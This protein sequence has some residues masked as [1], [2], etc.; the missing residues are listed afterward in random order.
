MTYTDPEVAQVGH[1]ELSA[2]DAGIPFEVTTYGIDDLDRAIAESEDHGQVKVLTVPGKDT[3]IGAN[4]VSH[5][6]GEM[7]AEF[8]TAM[9]YGIGMNKILGTIHSYPSFVEAN[10][11]A[12][13]NWK[14]AHAPAG[15]LEFVKKFHRWRR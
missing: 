3:I 7:I 11:Y 6:A 9:K 14:K 13:G 10:K 5:N 1:N 15:L 8:V 4:I 12:A 2:K